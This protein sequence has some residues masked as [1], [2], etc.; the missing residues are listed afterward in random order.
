L[1][2][3]QITNND[4]PDGIGG[5]IL[6]NPHATLIMKGT[7]V[8][9]NHSG[10]A[11]GQGLGG[12]VMANSYCTIDITDSTFTNNTVDGQ[13]GGF[14]AAVFDN[15]NSTITI[16]GSTFSQNTAKTSGGGVYSNANSTISVTDSKFLNNTAAF[17]GGIIT[18]GEQEFT[19]TSSTISGNTALAGG[20]VLVNGGYGPITVDSSTF[21]G[22]SATS[23]NPSYIYGGG[24]FYSFGGFG[25]YSAP[26]LIR[27]STIVG[28]TS[29]RG[30]GGIMVAVQYSDLTIEESTIVNNT[31]SS[32]GTVFGYPVGGGG[33]EVIFAPG[34]VTASNSVIAQ[35]I[36]VGGEPDISCSSPVNL[37]H[38][39]IGDMT[40]FTAIGTSVVTPGTPLGLGT[41]GDYGGPNQTVPLLPTS[42][43]RDVGD[44]SLLGT[45]TT[46]ERGFDRPSTL[47]PTTDV[48]AYEIQPL[49]VTIDQSGTTNDPSNGAA[50]IT[51]DV[52]F[53]EPVI[54]FDD[55]ADVDL[56]GSDV[57]L[58]TLTATIAPIGTSQSDYTV[59]VSGMTPGTEGNIVAVIEP[60]VATDGAQF[61]NSASTSID[62]TVTFDDVAPTVTINKDGGQADPTNVASIDFMVH[63]SEPVVGF[64]PGSVDLSGSTGVG[65]PAVN[66]V[67]PVGPS[68]YLVNVTGMN[69]TG[70]VV[71]KIL[72]GAVTDAAGNN[73]IASTSTDNSVAFDN[74]KP[75]V[76]INKGA[77]Q[78]DPTS[79]NP[80]TFDIV[81]SEPV[82]GFT[83][84][85]VDISSTTAGGTFITNL[86]QVDPTHYTFTVDGITSRGDVIATIPA[87][88]FTDV[89]GNNN[90]ASTSTDNIVAW[91]KAGVINLSASTV[92]TTEGATITIT[93]TRTG[94]T[95]GIV[96]VDYN[97]LTGTAHASDFQAAAGFSLSGTL[98]WADGDVTSQTFDIK[99]I[100]DGNNE[101]KE[102]FTVNL[103][104]PVGGV[105]IG[106]TATETVSIAPSDGQVINGAAVKPAKPQFVFIDGDGDLVTVKLNGKVGTATVFLTDPDGD[107]HG[108]LELIQLAGTNAK[109]ALVITSAKA[110]KGT[111]DGRNSLAEL[112]GTDLKAL[113]ATK[114]DLNGPGITMSGF[115]NTVSV[116]SISGG[117]DISVAGAAPAGAKGAGVGVSVTSA[118]AIGN[119]TDI[120]LAQVPLVKLKAYSVGTGGTISAPYAGTI[121]TV[122]NKKA[123]DP[124]NFGSNITLSGVGVPAK[125]LALKGINIKGAANGITIKVASGTGING[126]VG[127]ASFGSFTNSRLLAGYSGPDDG[128]G[129]F[130]LGSTI[131][132]FTVTGTVAAFAHSFVI[133]TNFKQASKLTSVDPANGGTKFGFVFHGLFGGLTLPSLKLKYNTKTGGTQTFSGDLQVLKV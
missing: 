33:V 62:N 20:G 5:G 44:N 115:L 30:G 29:A 116:G 133:G 95:D 47:N 14:G 32:T 70:N 131:G 71:A 83:A 100:D 121:Q 118:L 27:N 19:L 120:T 108:P 28:N 17:G 23:T 56:S 96:S 54:G 111:G 128:S 50:T 16:T 21:T 67:T 81:L 37:K 105:T 38:S 126:D 7:T 79:L 31:S 92:T 35:N 22:N 119:G 130:N 89:V 9:G 73:N 125:T 15:G 74:V 46:D 117:A 113:T 41:L 85:D 82:S 48:G 84:G 99:I 18:F 76:T 114:T 59:T 49:N 12:G 11:A 43:L 104:N 77:T 129:A 80:V 3:S 72:A 106:G 69:G 39:A 88:G 102:N 40:G 51:F 63:F 8:S 4:A 87:G 6:L 93:A 68:D 2:D 57:V 45:V 86:T 53:S 13:A 66:T 101:G 25:T 1:I 91:L 61:P 97:T 26:I 107:G 34:V 127:A 42:P 60:G 124:G 103:T 55:P 122:G 24:A 123:G 109:S 10:S 110:K 65:T 52:H 98:Q 78:A 36:N 94:G 64:G 112:T 132:K 75:T 90:V 58:G